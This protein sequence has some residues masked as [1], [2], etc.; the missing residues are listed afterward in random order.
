MDNVRSQIIRL[1]HWLF[2]YRDSLFPVVFLLLI[3]TTQ[4]AFPFGSERWDHWMD[5]LGFL[6]ML[7]GQGCRALAIGCAQNIRRRGRQKRITARKL[8]RTGFFAHSRNP[9]YLGNLLISFGLVVMA[10]SYWWYVVALPGVIGMYWAVVLAE[11]EFL[12]KQFGHEYVEYCSKVN[13]FLPRVAGL[14]Q[15]LVDSPFD[16]QRVVRKESQV[17]CSW[18][19]FAIGVLIWERVRQFGVA[20][21][22]TEIV[23]LVLI[24]LAFYVVYGVILCLKR[25][26]MLHAELPAGEGELGKSK[27]VNT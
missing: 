1:G 23:L 5:A 22:R 19:T 3:V 25:K 2:G 21:R 10:N 14:R 6:I 11:E 27:Q 9:L 18:V 4:P 8:I 13:R 24:L 26:G 12:A 15:S 20:A 16:W 7:T 17:V